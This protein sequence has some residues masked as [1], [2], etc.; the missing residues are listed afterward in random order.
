M[1]RMVGL[2]L[3]ALVCGGS[4]LY[5]HA[6]SPT[7]VDPLPTPQEALDPCDCETKP[8]GYVRSLSCN[9]TACHGAI[10]PAE[11]D[12]GLLRNEYRTWFDSDPHAHA[13][14]VLGNEVSQQMV[15]HLVGDA[16]S[17][18][19]YK[20][21]YKRCLACHNTEG[22][23][24]PNVLVKDPAYFDG[25]D[26]FEGVG[27]EMCHGKASEWKDIHYFDCWKEMTVTEKHDRGLWDTKTLS[28]RAAICVRCHVGEMGWDVDHDLIAAG[29]PQMKF[30]MLGYHT[31]MPHHWNEKHD[32][33]AGFETE[34]WAAGQSAVANAALA[35]LEHRA[36][37]ASGHDGRWVEFSEY[38]CFA[39]HHDV[40]DASWR[41]VRGFTPP[42]GNRVLLP[43][44]VW[45][46]AVLPELARGEP[47]PESKAFAQAV[48]ALKSTMQGS[49]FPDR[50][51]V[52]NQAIAARHALE[53]WSRKEPPAQMAERLAPFLHQRN[54][55][56]PQLRNWD[57]AVQIYLAAY[58]VLLSQSRAAD[59]PSSSWTATA[60]SLRQGLKF[61]PGY[62]SPH[63]FPLTSDSK[64]EVQTRLDNLLKNLP[65]QPP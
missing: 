4:Y 15:K 45:H 50:K 48:D 26:R 11:M 10:E 38:D 54:A 36:T 23:E 55:S 33:V 63:D 41:R 56:K 16:P 8:A 37:L 43:W 28:K 32:D 31:L 34:L 57:E 44:G 51:T 2:L 64:D 60:E 53:A 59:G 18:E 27:C 5:W 7:D 40:L 17:A 58:A 20:T 6:N 35:L 46:F 65:E 42:G 47:I 30:E 24:A 14:R 22:A 12:E 49:V 39:C 3:V 13:A 62:Q 1:R 21:I 61:G 25:D 9:S 29:H 19:K 52:K